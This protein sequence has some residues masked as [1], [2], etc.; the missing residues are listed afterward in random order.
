MEAAKQEAFKGVKQD[1]ANETLPDAKLV[2]E[3]VYH[4]YPMQL[5]LMGLLLLVGTI[6]VVTLSKRQIN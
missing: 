6:G 2:G 3:T 5:Q 1:L 4:K